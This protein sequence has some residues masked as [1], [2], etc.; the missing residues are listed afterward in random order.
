MPALR[1]SPGSGPISLGHGLPSS[2]SANYFHSP[3]NRCKSVCLHLLLVESADWSVGSRRTWST[4]HT[5]PA[6]LHLLPKLFPSQS[7]PHQI[8]C[9]I[10]SRRR[11]RPSTLHNSSTTTLCPTEFFCTV[12]TA[13]LPKAQRPLDEAPSWAHRSAPSGSGAERRLELELLSAGLSEV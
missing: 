1:L 13:W 10:S 9:K 12:K 4:C 11:R 6:L 8:A 3:T 2:R 5:T 7:P